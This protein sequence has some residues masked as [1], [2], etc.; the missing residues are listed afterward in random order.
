MGFQYIPD[1]DTKYMY[2]Y[3]PSSPTAP[4]KRV[5]RYGPEGPPGKSDERERLERAGWTTTRYA[6]MMYR[7]ED[8]PIVSGSHEE[9]ERMIAEG[10]SKTAPLTGSQA[11]PHA[12]DTARKRYLA[13]REL[14]KGGVKEPVI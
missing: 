13:S 9:T 2:L 5:R 7:G 3:D 4:A 8:P 6:Q 14:K 10:W 12:N 1:D 11:S